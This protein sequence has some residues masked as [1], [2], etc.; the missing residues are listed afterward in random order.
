MFHYIALGSTS[1][2]SGSAHYLNLAGTGIL[3]DSGQDPNIDGV[4]GLPDFNLLEKHPDW[5]VDYAIL[6]HAHHDHIG[7]LPVML[8]HFPHARIH[9][10]QPTRLLL[11]F[12]LPE[13]ARLQK[14]R[15]KEGVNAHPPMFTEEQAEL[16]AYLYRSWPLETPFDLNE[17][18]RAQASIQAT[19]YHA[20]HTLGAVGTLLEVEQGEQAF[21]AFYSGDLSLRAQAIQPGADFP[22]GPVDVLILESTL[23]ADPTAE[24][25]T[26]KREEDRLL[27]GIQKTI[28]RKGSVLIPAFALGRSQEMIAL[29]GRWKKQ[30]KLPEDL[31]IYTAGAQRAISDIYDR[32]R[33]ISP[34]IDEKFEVFK[35]EQKR[36][37]KSKAKLDHLISGE[38]P[39]I[40]IVGSGMLFERTL[41]HRIALK[42]IGDPRHSIFFVGYVKP[43]CPGAVLLEAA[44]NRTTEKV[45]LDP[46]HQPEGMT[47]ACTV[48]RFRF[49]GHSNRRELLQVVEKLQPRKVLLVHGED[50]ARIWMA[51]NIRYFYPDTEVILPTQGV[52]VLVA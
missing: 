32:T 10:T 20:G 18:V 23:G 52:P 49:S 17:G 29:I 16:A 42:M 6:S 34:R 31:P 7:S 14:K 38:E 26:R 2:I 24:L 33:F 9:M 22:K 39:G 1:E 21:R 48:E 44:Q 46:L 5:G 36:L 51:D 4:A 13:S 25:T 12:L 30:K 27:E 35:I 28:K 41:S 45:A 15:F 3:L 37:P 47:I 8:R 40:F 19:F 43:D 11:D 50:E